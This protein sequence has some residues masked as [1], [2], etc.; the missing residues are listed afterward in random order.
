M[1]GWLRIRGVHEVASA[2]REPPEGEAADRRGGRAG[3]PVRTGVEEALPR[4]RGAERASAKCHRQ[5]TESAAQRSGHRRGGSQYSALVAGDDGHVSGVRLVVAA[6]GA[7]GAA[8]PEWS[9]A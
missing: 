8:A 1:P 2:V 9:R 6:D 4:P 7:V 5:Y 3:R